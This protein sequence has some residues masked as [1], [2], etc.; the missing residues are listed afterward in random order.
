M[1]TNNPVGSTAELYIKKLP[2]GVA[3][4]DFD[5]MTGAQLCADAHFD[6]NSLTCPVDVQMDGGTETSDASDRCNPDA[7]IITKTT[8]ELSFNFKKKWDVT[9]GVLPQW[10]Q[11]LRNCWKECGNV[12]VLMLDRPKAAGADGYWMIGQVTGY[13]ENQPLTDIIDISVT[14]VPSG[15][16]GAIKNCGCVTC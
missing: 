3:L 11:D 13:S 8:K 9:T 1:P 4:P 2:D 16:T 6:A 15:N 14:I 12:C 5:A 10:V 7:T